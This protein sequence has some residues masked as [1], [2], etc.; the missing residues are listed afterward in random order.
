MPLVDHGEPDA[1]EEAITT[2]PG[3]ELTVEKPGVLLVVHPATRPTDDLVDG[4]VR[5]S[6]RSAMAARRSSRVMPGVDKSVVS[7]LLSGRK[8]PTE[9]RI[10]AKIEAALGGG[11]QA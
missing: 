4:C 10:L 7:R 1:D 3:G 2:D 5:I 6:P 8:P 11:E 9:K